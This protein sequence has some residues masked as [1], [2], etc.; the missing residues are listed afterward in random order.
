[1]VSITS[2]HIAT[3]QARVAV[4]AACGLALVETDP[5]V[6]VDLDVRIRGLTR[7]LGMNRRL[8]I[9]DVS[10]G[11]ATLDQVVRQL[12]RSR[13]PRAFR[14]LTADDRDRVSVVPVGGRKLLRDKGT[15]IDETAISNIIAELATTSVVVVNL[16]SVPGPLPVREV[17]LQSDAVLLAV[18]DG[19]TEIDAA[20][21][22]VDAL[23]AAVPNRVGYLLV[24]Q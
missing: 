2:N 15:T 20:L 21:T 14:K 1:M 13:I 12:P 16:P 24:D 6:I 7:Q 3:L 9:V 22:T 18:L 11:H 8:G 5:V 10:L 17:L 19:W 23:E 4:G